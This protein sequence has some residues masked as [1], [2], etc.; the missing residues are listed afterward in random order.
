MRTGLVLLFAGAVAACASSPTPEGTPDAPPD[1]EW[2]PDGGMELAQV[3]TAPLN[4]LNLV[5]AEIPPILVTAQKAPYAIPAD[6]SCSALEAEIREL[7]MVLGAD[8]DTR[9][10]PANPG[11]VER[12]ADYVGEAAVGAVRGAAESVVPFR[13]W[14]RRLSGAER[15]SKEVA[16]AIAAGTIHRAFLKGVRQGEGCPDP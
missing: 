10:T 11:L 13:K 8:L 14:V 12:G 7:D 4:D 16:A 5:R 9:P 1:R 2:R 15:Y 3:A 6:R